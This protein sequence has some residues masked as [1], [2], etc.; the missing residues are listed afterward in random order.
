MLSLVLR[1]FGR[2]R[3][4]FIGV[5]ALLIGFQL[6]LIATA[7][8]LGATTDFERLA[9][10][11]PTFIQHALGLALAS[12][13]GMTALAY[14][15]PLVVLVLAQFAIYVA[16]EPAGDIE[17]G[18]VDLLLARPLPRHWLI[19]RSVVLMAGLIV[20]AVAAM[21]LS[22]W[23]GLLLF[24]P[25]GALWPAPAILQSLAL[26]LAAV[27]WCFGGVAV[28]V[29]AW[30]Q[31]RASALGIVA[32]AAVALYLLEFVARSWSA[33][34]PLGPLSPFHY[35]AGADV[36]AGRS[37]SAL[38]LSVLGAVGAAGV[39]IAYWRFSRRDV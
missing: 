16:T 30:S 34:E 37:N 17:S 22:T 1:S 11:V 24:A 25:P 12:F 6:T 4:L 33:A 23:V 28:A 9:Q 10:A 27:A 39:V 7:A 2:I 19:T 36:L 35:F 8:S 15:E 32:L 5:V 3:S 18:L 21:R 14:F 29:A 31:R 20:V 38:D 13:A 26:H